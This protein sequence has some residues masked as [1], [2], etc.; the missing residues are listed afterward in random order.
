ML[1][2]K[3]PLKKQITQ[4][5]IEHQLLSPFTSFIA[6][7]EKISRKKDAALKTQPVKKF[8]A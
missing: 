8:N 2:L 5:A 7:E 3:Q 4:L 1:K 6:V